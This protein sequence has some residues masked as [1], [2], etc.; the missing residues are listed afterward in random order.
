MTKLT[1]AA[2]LFFGADCCPKDAAQVSF[3][4]H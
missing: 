1:A 2:A 4:K 3:P